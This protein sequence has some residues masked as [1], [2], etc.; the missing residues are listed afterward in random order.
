MN[1][2]VTGAAAIAL[3]IGLVA[4]STPKPPL[5]PRA[6]THL[7]ARSNT[8]VSGT[9]EF[10]QVG[11]QVEVKVVAT[12]LSRNQE[13]GFHIHEKGDCNSPD[14]MSAFSFVDAQTG[15]GASASGIF[16]TTDGG[17][18]FASVLAGE[19]VAVTALSSSTAVAIV[20]GI[21]FRSSNGGSTWT[22]GASASGR[23]R[24]LKVSADVVLAYGRGGTFPDFDDRILRSDDGG[25]T[26]IDLGEV[27]PATAYAA[28]LN[29]TVLSASI[30]V[31][32]DGSGNLYR[33]IDAG[34]SWSMSHATPGPSQGFF[35]NGPADF[36][37]AQTGYIGY[38]SGYLLRSDD[39][40][41][42]W[43][44]IS[45]GSGI[46]IMD[47]DRFSNGDLIA[48]GTSGQVLTRSAGSTSWTIRGTLG[49]ATLEAVQVTGPQQGNRRL[50][51]QGTEGAVLLE[52]LLE[53][54][55]RVRHGNTI[56]RII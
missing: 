15:L 20:D 19:A 21:I 47:M 10:K 38:G 41:A 43:T 50:L 4:C 26:W 11:D 39:G 51:A 7:S 6:A 12:N 55:G 34:L 48:V 35:S 23:N 13:H 45:S 53:A 31:A 56:Q 44:Q 5:A 32:S 49:E 14:G 46:D 9:V 22:A 18:S 24:L 8:K 2:R 3:S 33:S 42:S 40:G 37:D 36:V 27:I 52:L 29:F 54:A 16:R 28:D 25:Q 1:L 30:I 17:T